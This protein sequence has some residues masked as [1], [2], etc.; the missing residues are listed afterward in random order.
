[1]VKD[2]DIFEG[3]DADEQ[4]AVI[5]SGFPLVWW[6]T[7]GKIQNKAGALVIPEGNYLQERLSEV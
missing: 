2:A 6:E 3:D 4:A 7:F 1:M 5:Y